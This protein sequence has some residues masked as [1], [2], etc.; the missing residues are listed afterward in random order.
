MEDASV[1]GE[2]FASLLFSASA[3]CLLI[4]SIAGESSLFMPQ[5]FLRAE[6][7]ET[8]REEACTI[9]AHRLLAKFTLNF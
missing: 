5:I 4:K 6:L 3:Y 1:S 7:G 2:A 8:A 9:I